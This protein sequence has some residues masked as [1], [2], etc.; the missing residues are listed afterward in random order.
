MIKKI[1]KSL[2]H[3]A[4][5]NRKFYYNE[6]A[7]L[8]TSVRSPRVL[9]L[10]SGV[11]VGE[12][13]SY[14]TKHLFRDYKEFLQT[15]VNP[16]F[17]H[18]IVDATT[19]NYKDRFDVI[20]CLNVLEH[21]FEHQKAVDNMHRALKKGGKLVVAVPFCFPLHDEPGDYWRYT[22]HALRKILKDFS[23]VELKHQ[24]AR[25][26]PSGYFAIAEK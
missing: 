14:S 26:L 13:Y 17:G 20:L 7:K 19:M 21:I 9:E 6:V 25:L 2:V 16:D 18:K 11:K 3:A 24:R 1:L 23:H 8:A 22:E 10:G 12:S 4:T 15:D 5:G